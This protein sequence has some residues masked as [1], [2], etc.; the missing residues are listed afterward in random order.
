MIG[1]RRLAWAALLV[2]AP[3][4]ATDRPAKVA[5]TPKSGDAVLIVRAPTLPVPYQIGISRFDP[6]ESQLTSNPLGGWADMTVSADK[7]TDGYIVRTV[8]PGT[9]V[10]RDV[11]QQLAWGLCFHA[12]TLQF[13]VRPGE[14]VYLGSFDGET[15]IRELQR[16][17]IA[18]MDL[19]ARSGTVHHYFDD[20]TPPTFTAATAE[21]MDRVRA[22]V[23][24]SM[25]KTSVAPSA[26][27]FR[28]ARFG[29]GSDLFGTQKVCGGYYKKKVGAAPAG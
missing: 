7:S 1:V 23:A 4:A 8:K 16:E 22:F 13:D 14:V 15:P 20:V 11:S 6:V 18:H 24:N 29:T 2:A 26:V 19:V 10:L 9:Y 5:I 28:P 3:A 12:D 17:A 25:P 21:D 27:A